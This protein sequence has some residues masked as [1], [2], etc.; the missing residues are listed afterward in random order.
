M[1]SFNSLA[2]F[3]NCNVTLLFLD[4]YNNTFGEQS[5]PI[6][7]LVVFSCLLCTFGM[8]LALGIVLFEKNGLNPGNR[9][10]VDMVR[11][12]DCH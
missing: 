10:L 3:C 1:T 9:Q 11:S 5:M 7:L 4:P 6:I 2:R 12:S 8:F